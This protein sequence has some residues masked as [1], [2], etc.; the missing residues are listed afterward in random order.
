MH[1]KK[2]YRQFAAGI[3]LGISVFLHCGYYSFSGSTL[4]GHIKKVHV[5][6]FKDQ[7]AEFGINQTLTDKIIEA[8]TK[9]N[10]LK[11]ADRRQ[12]DAL[13]TGKIT[14]VRERA[15]S[16][17]A[18]EVA[19]SFRIY[20]TIEASFEDLK[21]RNMLWEETWTEWGE[22]ETDREAGISAAIEKLAENIVNET[23][24]GW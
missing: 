9:D 16:Y 19:A 24:S 10:T 4:S 18:D 14:S 7:T 22:Y 3:F 1:R 21:K 13:L 2:I 20:I 11:I 12:T 17:T 5:P 23:V 8:I 15:G 6:L